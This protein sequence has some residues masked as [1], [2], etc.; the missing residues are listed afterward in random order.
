M[1][2]E[3]RADNTITTV[4]QLFMNAM[5]Q[6]VEYEKALATISKYD[7]VSAVAVKEVTPKV[8]PQPETL[9]FGCGRKGHVRERCLFQTHPDFN[10]DGSSYPHEK[11]LDFKRRL[12]GT[13]LDVA[14]KT[15]NTH[16]KDNKQNKRHK[17]GPN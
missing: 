10:R 7:V 15:P 16:G 14:I 8:T 12:D 9:C 5:K 17:Y 4:K 1:H 3:I 11:Q 6:A 2:D 13:L